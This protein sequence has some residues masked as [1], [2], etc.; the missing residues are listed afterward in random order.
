[1]HRRYGR[2]LPRWLLALLFMLALAAFTGYISGMGITESKPVMAEDADVEGE[3]TNVLYVPESEAES[4]YEPHYIT[5]RD[6]SGDIKGMYDKIV[7]LDPGHGGIDDGAS[8][9]GI[10]EQDINMAVALLVKE[11][12]EEQTDIHPILSRTD[13]YGPKSLDRA[14]QASS[15]AD[16]LVSIHCNTYGEQGID[17]EVHGTEVHY[18]PDQILADNPRFRLDSSELA[19]ILLDSVCKAAGSKSRGLFDKTDLVITSNATIPCVLVEM[20]FMSNAEERKKLNSQEY[21][22]MLARGIYN[23]IVAAFDIEVKQ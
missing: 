12:L 20:G 22:Q 18:S 23:G 10:K 5:V 1:M 6:D 15:E 8:R 2:R 9:N 11:M 16:M 3:Y 14:A 19:A 7:C 17:N 13:E 4:N 21:Q